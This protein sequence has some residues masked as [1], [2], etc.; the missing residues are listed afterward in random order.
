MSDSSGEKTEEPTQK[1]INDSRK[2]GQ[3]WKSKDLTGVAVFLVG[4]ATVQMIWP[5][6]DREIRTLFAFGFDRLS[7]PQ[8]LEEAALEVL[9]MGLRSVMLLSI[10][11]GIACAMIGGIIEF[12]QVGALFS[13]KAI[14]PKFEKLD[15]IKGM[16]N[17]VGKKQLVELL[18]N[19]LKMGLAGYVVW[20]AVSSRLTMV[21]ETVRNDVPAIM[22]VLGE[23]VTTI[24]MRVGL[25]FAAFGI[26]DVWWQRRTYYEDL[27]MT[28]D[29]VKK[30]YKQSEGDPH[31]KAKRK[32]LH[33]E[34]LESAQMES[35]KDADVVVTNPDHVA[36]ALRYDASRDGAPRVLAKGLDGRAEAIKALARQADVPLMRNVPLAHALFRVEVHDEIPEALY[37][38]VAEVLN[39]V[40]GLQE[41]R[42]VSN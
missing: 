32:E 19:L 28:K 15:A 34:I 21:V 30:E 36:V 7:H 18:K 22:G 27:K 25:L 29:E 8:D 33:Q 31:H 2:E 6:V 41:Q 37:D 10:P 12:L 5:M 11:V 23:L 39:F 13:P 17:L 35:V 1:K 14:M 4:L 20:G 42:A 9:V 16:K 26:F 40:H 24:A 3:V 38:A